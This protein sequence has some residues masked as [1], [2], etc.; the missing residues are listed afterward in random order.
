MIVVVCLIHRYKGIKFSLR[1]D[2]P[3]SSPI[4]PYLTKITNRTILLLPGVSGAKNLNSNRFKMKKDSSKEFQR[5]VVTSIIKVRII[6]TIHTKIKMILMRA[7]LII[8]MGIQDL[9]PRIVEGMITILW[10]DSHR[11]IKDNEKLG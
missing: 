4:M 7:Y 2:P 1:C 5:K 8:L 6:S 10:R 11:F 3:K 9:W